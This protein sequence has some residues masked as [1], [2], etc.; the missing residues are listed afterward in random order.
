[1]FAQKISRR[2]EPQAD[3][4]PADARS[5]LWRSS[6]ATTLPGVTAVGPQK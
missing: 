6:A 4:A 2:R 5:A 3:V 1:M